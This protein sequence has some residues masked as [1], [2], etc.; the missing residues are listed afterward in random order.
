V[1]VLILGIFAGLATGLVENDPAT[2]PASKDRYYGFPLVWRLVNANSG[3]K[4]I[5]YA[6]L[7]VDIVFGMVIAAVMVAVALMTAKLMEKKVP[8]KTNK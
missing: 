8:P 5:F 4:A 3:Q 7:L 2:A 1:L 6:E